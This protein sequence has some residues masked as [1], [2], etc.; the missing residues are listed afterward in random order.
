[1]SADERFPDFLDFLV[2]FA[3]FSQGERTRRLRFFEIGGEIS[4]GCAL[5]LGKISQ[6]AQNLQLKKKIDKIC[7]TSNFF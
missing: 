7:K 1:M 5:D 3:I 2:F 4:R 6:I